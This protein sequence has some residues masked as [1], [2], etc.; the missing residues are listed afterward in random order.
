[1]NRPEETLNALREHEG[2]IWM[3]T[4]EVGRMAE[5]GFVYVVD[6]AKDMIIVGG[7]KVFSSEVEDKLFKHPAIEMCALV[8]VPNPERPDSEIVK[9][10]IQKS[11]AYKDVSDEKD[12]RPPPVI[13]GNCMGH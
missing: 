8:G 9:I 12:A 4:G 6:R 1:M 7:Y 5:D 3:H 10:F 11:A 2:E 13:G